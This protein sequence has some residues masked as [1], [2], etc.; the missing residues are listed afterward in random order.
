MQKHYDI[1]LLGSGQIAQAILKN[2]LD[3]SVLVLSRSPEKIIDRSNFSERKWIAGQSVIPSGVTGD[4]VINCIMPETRRVSRSVIDCGLKLL[5]ETGRYIHLSTI[6][7]K[8][9]PIDNN[10]FLGFSGDVYIRVKRYEL[11]Y[12]KTKKAN[13]LIIYP[14]I[15]IGGNTG[16]DKFFAK[17]QVSETVSF[18]QSL[19]SRAPIIKIMD[20]ADDILR[21]SS[22]E[23]STIDC[24]LPDPNE[25]ALPTWGECV[26]PLCSDITI[27]NYTYFPSKIKNSIV[28]VL[29]GILVPTWVWEKIHKLSKKNKP[30]KPLTVQKSKNEEQHINVTGMTNFYIGCKYVL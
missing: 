15:V 29:N 26:Q 28:T 6:A 27:L 23:T 30:E 21:A 19:N 5:S 20:L 11:K 17:L 22:L 9:K 14:G 25:V 16:W 7:V 10:P 2:C 18:G 24:F 3:K 8:S 13:M 4:L 1:I 12:L